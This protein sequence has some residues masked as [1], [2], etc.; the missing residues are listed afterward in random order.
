MKYRLSLLSLRS[1]L[2]DGFIF[3][4]FFQL[5][6]DLHSGAGGWSCRQQGDDLSRGSSVGEAVGGGRGGNGL[7]G[8]IGL[9]APIAR[10]ESLDELDIS[11]VRM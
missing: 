1:L 4:F 11:Q 2:V 10:L 8:S 5:S 6:E 7:G 3:L 9:E